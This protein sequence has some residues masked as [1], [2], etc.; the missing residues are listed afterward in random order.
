MSL[1]GADCSLI[2]GVSSRSACGCICKCYPDGAAF[3]DVESTTPANTQAIEHRGCRRLAAGLVRLDLAKN[4]GLEDA[5]KLLAGEALEADEDEEDAAA[6]EMKDKAGNKPQ[7][8]L[9]WSNPQY[10]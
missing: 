7:V 10:T 2:H 4:K 6:Q 8:R 9:L 5:Q 1:S 3:H